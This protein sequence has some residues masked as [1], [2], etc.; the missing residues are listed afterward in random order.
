MN[1]SGYDCP[2]IGISLSFT[3]SHGPFP[4]FASEARLASR[5]VDFD[6]KTGPGL[7]EQQSSTCLRSGFPCQLE[8]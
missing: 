4:V 2:S 8:P 7:P 1:S 5:L 3:L 6:V